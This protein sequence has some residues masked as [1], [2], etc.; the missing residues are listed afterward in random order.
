M[1][2]QD[3]APNEGRYTLPFSTGSSSP[4]SSALT[5]LILLLMV[6]AFGRGA[7]AAGT[8]A[9]LKG[10]ALGIAADD[11]QLRAVRIAIDGDCSCPAFDGSPT[12][13]HKDYI[14]CANAIVQAES[15]AGRLRTPCK[16]TAA[17]YAKFSTCGFNPAL[18]YEPCLVK[19]NATG[20]VKCKLKPTTQ[21]DGVTPNDK[22]VSTAKT[23]AVGC[24]FETHCLDAGDTNDDLQIAA[25]GDTG[26]CVDAQTTCA[27]LAAL[28]STECDVTPGVGGTLLV[29]DVLASDRLYQGGRVL[30]DAQGM[31]SCVGC[32]CA[33]AGATQILCPR[34]AISPGFINAHDQLAYTHNDP[35]T[36]TGERY[37]QRHD[38]RKGKNGHTI[39][40]AAGNANASQIRWGELRSVM[41]GATSTVGSGGRAGL[42]RNLDDAN[43]QE[44][45]A[46]TAVDA[47][48]FPL[49]DAN[50]TQLAS[51]CSYPAI[52][53]QGHV[54][55]EDSYLGDI[56]EGID[57]YA[58][59]EFSCLSSTNN[60][61]E[62]ILLPQTGLVQG[63][64]LSAADLDAMA[65]RGTAIIWSPR[66]N[67]R[68]YGNTAPV[69]AASALDVEIALGTDWI[70]TG[71]S[72]LLRELRCA[73]SFNRTYLNGVFKDRDLWKMATLS[74]ARATATDDVIGSLEPGKFGDVAVFRE[75]AHTGYRAAIAA[76][77][78][79][80][81]LVMRGG[82]PLYGDSNVISALPGTDCDDVDVCGSAKQ[83]C[84]TDEI[85]QTLAQLQA[86]VGGIYPA[87]AC[88]TPTNEPTCVPSRTASVNGSTVYTGVVDP[89]DLDGDGIPN[90]SDNCPAVFN[91]IRPM[92]NGAQPDSD[93]DGLGDDCDPS[94]LPAAP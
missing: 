72:T 34:A 63:I 60:G 45:V 19:A 30:I 4:V 53:G 59:N 90:A 36:D 49:G 78:Q 57:A 84:T 3:P 81:V 39:I 91:P 40:T 14:A 92:D 46:Q 38:W 65:H 79:D 12:K 80:V 77:P 31:I 16:K 20:G 93:S 88:G 71:S 52:I 70:V 82:T 24:P 37:E 6:I 17:R 89:G 32:D 35:S 58:S 41:S 55:A 61:G 76:D 43:L 51:G 18:N 2:G 73:D 64:G 62:D 66:S 22:C 86:Q 10:D 1:T 74:A 7:S 23:T 26:L 47:D 9:C 75:S 42:V 48:L 25:P 15:A 68:L 44:G 13:T 11:A 5:A 33:D 87:F 50:G 94:P 85:G 83:V 54:A 27:H 56:S 29:G 67:L 8:A 28:P 21:P 69:R